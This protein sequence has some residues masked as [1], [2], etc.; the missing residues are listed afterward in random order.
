[1]NDNHSCR[2]PNVPNASQARASVCGEYCAFGN[3]I[4]GIIWELDGIKQ[5]LI[6]ITSKELS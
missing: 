5:F 1:M 3:K 2:P 6:D 4:D